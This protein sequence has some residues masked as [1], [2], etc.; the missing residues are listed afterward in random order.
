MGAMSSWHHYFFLRIDLIG[1]GL[2]IFGLTL[3]TVFAGFHNYIEERNLIL[4]VMSFLMV[5]NLILQMTP[6]YAM[7]K[8]NSFRIIFY[9]LTL[10]LCLSIAITARF[11]FATPE[12]I[13]NFF[14]DLIMSF[15]WLAIGFWF[16]RNKYPESCLKRKK[17]C[18]KGSYLRK[19]ECREKIELFCP[20]H[21]WWHLFVVMNGYTLYW[22]SYRYNLHVEYYSDKNEPGAPPKII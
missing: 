17:D 21:F 2:M 5:S 18:K 6:C 7:E 10:F 20:S 19:K 8:Y 22:L 9:C 12:E 11:Y 13:N 4:S 14:T 3:C 16:F 1:I 15:V